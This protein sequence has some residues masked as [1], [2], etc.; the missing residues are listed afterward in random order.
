M[1]RDGL[2]TRHGDRALFAAGYDQHRHF[3]CRRRDR[4]VEILHAHQRDD[5]RLVGE[6]DVDQSVSHQRTEISAVARD[7]EHVRQCEGHLAPGPAR[8]VDRGAHRG[9]WFLGIPQIAFEIQDRGVGDQRMVERG[10]GQELRRAKKRVHRPLAIG[11]HEDQ[12]TRGGRL[13]VAGFGAERD[14]HRA[15]I[16]REDVAELVLG[17][18]ADKTTFAAQRRDTGD[19]VRRRTP[20]RL[21]PRTHLGIQRVGVLGREHQLH[22]SLGHTFRRDEGI[23]G[24]RQDIDNGISD[25][26]D[27]V[28]R[29][30]QSGRS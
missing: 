4:R 6:H 10:L 3:P 23:V 12:A 5:F 21:D 30:G 18:L 26:D 27:V 22:R 8:D 16:V 15:N 11:R 28:G 2:P 1:H 13:T 17:D 24:L 14:A 29:C 25:G 9:T 7:A 20:A 19:S